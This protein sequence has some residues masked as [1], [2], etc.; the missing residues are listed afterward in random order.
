VQ[1]NKKTWQDRRVRG[2]DEERIRGFEGGNHANERTAVAG[3]GKA[4]TEIGLSRGQRKELRRG[5]GHPA[6]TLATR[7]WG[8]KA[9]KSGPQEDRATSDLSYNNQGEKKRGTTN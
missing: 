1:T 7:E 9:K 4:V 8:G 2:R 5:G 6:K 3:L